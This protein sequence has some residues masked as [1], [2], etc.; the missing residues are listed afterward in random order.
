[1]ITWMLDDKLLRPPS[2]RFRCNY[3]GRTAHFQRDHHVTFHSLERDTINSKDH[4]HSARI[5]ES[6]DPATEETPS[7]VYVC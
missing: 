4:A 2:I 3:T 6:D 7:S 1:M 5:M